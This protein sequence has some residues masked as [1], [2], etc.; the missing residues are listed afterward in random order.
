M[1]REGDGFTLYGG[2]WYSPPWPGKGAGLHCTE[3]SGTPHH[4]QGR[5]RVYTVRRFL[6]LR[7][8]AREGDGFTPYGGFWYSPPW[9]GKGTGLHRTEVS[10]TPRHGQGRGRVYTVR[11]LLVLRAMAREGDGF[12]PYGGFWYSAPWPGKG[13]GL[14]RT[15]VSGTPRHGQGRGRVYTVRR[16]LV[17]RAMAR[18]GDGFTLHGGF[19]YSPPWPG[20]GTGLHRTEVSGTPR[21]GQGRGRVYTVRRF[22]VL[23]AMARVGDGFTPYG[24]FWY[25]APWPGKGTGLHRTEVSGTPRHGQG[26]GRVYTVRRFLV[27][28]AM[29]REGDGFT[30][31]G[32][33]W[34]SPPWPGKGTG[35]HCT[36]V[37]FS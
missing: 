15:E 21:H 12:T 11:R 32:G 16:F 34:Y 2:F 6:V 37:W 7:T 23:P 9:P 24:G 19:W 14:H 5:G 36:E 8:M 18:E 10:G 17:L 3:V 31:Y 29:A 25:S 30:P 28:R 26:R 22:L 27:L 33:F 1:T 4:G 20:K 13:T 35:L